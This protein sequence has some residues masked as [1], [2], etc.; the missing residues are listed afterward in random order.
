MSAGT[1]RFKWSLMLGAVV[2]LI[3]ASGCVLDGDADIPMDDGGTASQATPRGPRRRSRRSLRLRRRPRLLRSA[4]REP[5]SEKPR[6]CHPRQPPGPLPTSTVVFRVDCLSSMLFAGFSQPYEVG[7]P[8]IPDS[9]MNYDSKVP[10][11][12]G[13]VPLQ[14]SVLDEPDCSPHPFD[15]IAA[16]ALY[17]NVPRV[18]ISGPSSGLELTWIT[19]TAGVSGGALP[20]TYEWSAKPWSLAFSP[21]NESPSVSIYLPDVAGVDSVDERTI[22]IEVTV[23]D[24]NGTVAKDQHLILI[25]G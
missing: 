23:T 7:H 8:T 2:L 14:A 22:T 18:S 20:Y 15:V 4:C 13:W 12:A 17:Q 1:M 5:A 3:A 25:T 19:L 21:H 11:W 10:N 6:H 9:V 24:A 16:Y